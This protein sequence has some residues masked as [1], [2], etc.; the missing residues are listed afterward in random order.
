M[1]T[2]WANVIVGGM[3]LKR[4]DTSIDDGRAEVLSR[5]PGDPAL[6]R[7]HFPTTVSSHPE[8]LK[9]HDGRMSR[10]RQTEIRSGPAA[11]RTCLNLKA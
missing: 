8:R 3:S 4:L 1:S 10:V 5:R 9:L 7:P 11:I 2:Y 6:N